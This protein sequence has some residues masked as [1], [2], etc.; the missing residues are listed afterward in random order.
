MKVFLKAFA[1]AL[2][3]FILTVFILTNYSDYKFKGDALEVIGLTQMSQEGDGGIKI[4][5][6]VVPGGVPFGI[7]N[8]LPYILF[9]EID[10]NTCQLRI[11]AKHLGRFVGKGNEIDASAFIVKGEPFPFP[12]FRVFHAGHQKRDRFSGARMDRMG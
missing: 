10:L 4:R 2:S 7:K 6:M 3:L 12:D 9:P 8:Q 1:G 5:R 11:P